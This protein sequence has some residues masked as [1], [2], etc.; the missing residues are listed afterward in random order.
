MYVLCYLA[1]GSL[2]WKNLKPND[3]GLEKMMKMK[4]KTSPYD[5]FVN[6]PFEYSQIMDYIKNSC[7]DGIVDYRYIE[8]LLKQTSVSGKFKLD[9]KFDWMQAPTVQQALSGTQIFNLTQQINDCGQALNKNN[10]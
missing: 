8:N 4:V 9:N 7:S 5:L 3:A 1:T 10:I 6:M 2:P